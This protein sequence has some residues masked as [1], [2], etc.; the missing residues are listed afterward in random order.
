M[1]QLSLL[2][3]IM[4]L[5]TVRVHSIIYQIKFLDSFR[6]SDVMIFGKKPNTLEA[7]EIKQEVLE[8]IFLNAKIN[9]ISDTSTP[10]SLENLV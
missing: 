9:F 6:D 2:L 10:L 4:T 8:S 5:S 7:F 1:T 3:Y